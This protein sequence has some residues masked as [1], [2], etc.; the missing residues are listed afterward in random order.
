MQAIEAALA[1]LSP[2]LRAA[3]LLR[4][5]HGLEYG[6]IAR[7]LGIELGQV[8]ARTRP[9]G[10]TRASR[11]GASMSDELTTDERRALEVWAPMAPPLE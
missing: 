5:Y 6:D 8:S 11:G 2:E 4:E 3:F 9:D 1:E 10:V 7:S